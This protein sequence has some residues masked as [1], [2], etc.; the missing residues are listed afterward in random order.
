FMRRVKSD[1][2][3]RDRVHR[4]RDEALASPALAAYLGGLW[5]ELRAWLAA[6]H[7]RR[8]ASLHQRITAMLEALGRTLAADREIQ[9]W[10]DEQ[11]LQA[12]AALGAEHRPQTG[13]CSVA[14]A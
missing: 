12:A 13:R 10:I 1:E 14:Q 4:L 6:E 11:I 8:P 7:D 9:N 2:G 3:L 5:D